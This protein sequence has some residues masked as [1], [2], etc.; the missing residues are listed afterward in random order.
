MAE[1]YRQVRQKL[2]LPPE[3]PP[4]DFGIP[5]AGYMIMCVTSDGIIT[6][7]WYVVVL[8]ILLFSI[9]VAAVLP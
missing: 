7:F 3:G 4:P 1:V 8:M 2:G 5:L 6:K 9:G